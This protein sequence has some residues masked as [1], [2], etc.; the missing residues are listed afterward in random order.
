[1]N[2][3]KLAVTSA[4]VICLSPAANAADKDGRFSVRGLGGSKCSDLAA[5]VS[6]KNT[7][8]I[9]AYSAWLGGYLTASNRLISQTF[10]V[11]PSTSATDAV[12]LVSVVCQANPTNLVESA[13]YQALEAMN[14]IRIR[15]DSPLVTVQEGGKSLVIRQEALI[16][17]QTELTR[18]GLF[19][20]AADGKAS[21]AL[22]QAVRAFQK[23]QKLPESGLPDIDVLIRLK[24][25][26]PRK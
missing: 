4:L 9:Q 6:Q 7:A 10:D 16:T 25:A 22:A 21:P 5:A 26:P 23:A 14:S 11:V 20:G 24:L 15:Q 3:V 19:N 8:L 18:A 13:T 1:M 2:K 17:V 12:G